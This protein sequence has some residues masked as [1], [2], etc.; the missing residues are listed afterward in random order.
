MSF[1]A[2]EVDN[3]TSLHSQN[4][5]RSGTRKAARQTISEKEY[6]THDNRSYYRAD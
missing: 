2:R 1:N 6:T 4:H 3:G 5:S